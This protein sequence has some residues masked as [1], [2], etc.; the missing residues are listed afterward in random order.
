MIATMFGRSAI[1]S[2]QFRR[3]QVAAI[4][5][6]PHGDPNIQSLAQIAVIFING[7]VGRLHEIQYR[8]MH[9]DKIGA[10][11][12]RHVEQDRSLC[13]N[14][15]PSKTESRLNLSASLQQQAQTASFVLRSTWKRIRPACPRRTARRDEERLSSGADCGEIHPHPANHLAEMALKLRPKYLQVRPGIFLGVLFAIFHKVT[16]VTG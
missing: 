12:F 1:S 4:G 10:N 7:L 2:A 6:A 3:H 9:D 14:F 8:C 13:P 15:D 5:M 11:G 16:P